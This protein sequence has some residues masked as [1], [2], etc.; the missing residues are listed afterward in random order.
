[1]DTL[2]GDLLPRYVTAGNSPTRSWFIPVI[3]EYGQ[4]RTRKYH[5]IANAAA[6]RRLPP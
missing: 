1:M 3:T 2:T 5:L 4:Q 6:S